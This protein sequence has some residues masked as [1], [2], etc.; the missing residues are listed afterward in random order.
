MSA[1]EIINN[2]YQERAQRDKKFQ[3]IDSSIRTKDSNVTKKSENESESTSENIQVFRH[4]FRD[5]NSN[6]YSFFA[7]YQCNQRKVRQFV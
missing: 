6:R 1:N 5:Y 2:L 4:A 7:I 3:E